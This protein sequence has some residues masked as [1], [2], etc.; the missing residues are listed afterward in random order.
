MF[1]AIFVAAVSVA[2]LPPDADLKKRAEEMVARLGAAS[3][4][5][6][7][8]AVRDL[9]DLGYAA[10][11]AVLAGKKSPD[12]EISDRCGKLYPI[13]WRIDLEKRVERFLDQPHEAV[14]ADL[15][16]AARW[17]QITGDSKE[18]RQLYATMVKSIPDPLLDVELHPERLRQAYLDLTKDVYSRMTGRVTAA[19]TNLSVG[20]TN[21]EVLLFL[22]LGATGE[23]RPTAQPGISTSCFYQFLGASALH[24]YLSAESPNVPAR[25]LYAAWLEK[26]RHSTVLRRAM[27]TAAQYQVRECA[28]VVLKIAADRGTMVTVRSVAL[29]SFAKVGTKDDIKDLAPFLKDDMQIGVVI[30]SGER[31]TVQMRDA[32]LGAAVQLAG[33]SPSE[34]GFERRPPTTLSSVSYSY[35]AFASDEKRAAAHAKWREWAAANLKK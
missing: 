5:D 22:F 18:S 13:I 26:E 20:P 16:G 24:N 19:R 9:L 6:R 7:E 8:R 23:V 21:A 27:D 30:V 3:Y 17:I 10:K 4:R 33:L 31:W 15:P 11:D 14:P 34:M 29:L 1:P 25:K 12:S 2:G 28:P 35:F 32:A